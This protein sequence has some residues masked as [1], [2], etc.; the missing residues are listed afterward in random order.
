[1]FKFLFVASLLFSFSA[2]ASTVPR[3]VSCN[4]S[5]S[6]LEIEVAVDYVFWTFTVEDE[7]VHGQGAFQK[8]IDTEDAF[9][10]FDD[11]YALSYKSKKAVFVL[12]NGNAV[13]FSHCDI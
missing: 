3:K 2:L 13:F 5:Y 8:E 12:A 7:S 4:N 10:S 1:M 9:S 6:S 11:V